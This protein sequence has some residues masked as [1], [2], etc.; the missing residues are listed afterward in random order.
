MF[1]RLY[2]SKENLKNN[3]DVIKQHI[4]DNTGI[5][6]MVKA[7]AY[8]CGIVEVSKYLETLGIKDF[9]V[10]H[11]REA[12]M[13]RESGINSNILV[14]SEFLEPDIEDIIKYNIIVSCSD[15][16]LLKLLNE[17]AKSEGVFA[18]IHLKIDTGMGRLGFSKESIFEAANFIRDN[19]KNIIIDGIYSHLSSA[20][21]DENYTLKQLTDFDE[22]VSKLKNQGFKFNY[23]HILNSIGILKYSKYQ[24]THV[25]PGI[26]LYGY[27]ESIDD[28]NLKPILTLKAPVL[29]VNEIKEDT[30]ISYNGTYT[31]KKGEK[32]ATISLGYADG[33]PRACSNKYEFFIDGQKCK[34]VGN[35]CMDMCMINITDVKADIK[36]GDFI[37]VIASKDDIQ[38]IAR[39]SNTITYEIISKFGD[40]F[41]RIYK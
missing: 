31:A 37:T 41:E 22:I 1:P 28:F 3:V 5:I 27:P 13:L 38:N 9:G 35:V 14:T 25:R 2:I 16:K 26:I 12:V 18:K 21:S 24:Y 4:S 8:G 33:F 6:V 36:V 7:N 30:K 11:T 40:R 17:A 10:A 15:L 34:V 23:I 39:L 19:Y 20:D 32:I 29:R